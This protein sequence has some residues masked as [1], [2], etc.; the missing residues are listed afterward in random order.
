M[1]KFKLVEN[2]I[3]MGDDAGKVKWSARPVYTGEISFKNL[4]D[5][6]AEASAITSADVKAVLD[7]SVLMLRKY[8]PE[9]MIV[10]FGEL[11]SFRLSFGSEAVEN[12]EDFKVELIRRP[13][14]VF[15]PSVGVKDFGRIS[16][17]R[18][19]P[20]TKDEEKPIEPQP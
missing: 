20:A 19:K 5:E 18:V 2:T 10:R 14:V 1:A 3:R 7:R 6:I 11:G 17:V 13:K 12:I 9:G 15:T 8:L 4:C 16:Y